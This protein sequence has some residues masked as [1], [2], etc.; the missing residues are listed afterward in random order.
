MKNVAIIYLILFFLIQLYEDDE[1]A[2]HNADKKSVAS[3]AADEDSDDDRDLQD[4]RSPRETTPNVHRAHRE[5]TPNVHRQGREMTPNVTV[6]V[7]QP[8]E[9]TT[10]VTN[11]DHD[12]VNRTKVSVPNY[13]VIV[14]SSRYKSYI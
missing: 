5:S 2:D 8:E 1:A 14:M 4:S 13:R 10:P 7:S 6:T 9:T 3:S 12:N 11:T